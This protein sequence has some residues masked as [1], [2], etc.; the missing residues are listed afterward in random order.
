MTAN[1]SMSLPY[2]LS[3][4][5]ACLLPAAWGPSAQACTGASMLCS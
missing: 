1:A 4:L 5:H 3:M 2:I